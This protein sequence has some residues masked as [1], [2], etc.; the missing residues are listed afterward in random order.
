MTNTLWL[1]VYFHDT[2]YHGAEDWPPA[3]ARVFQ[4]LLSGAS[5][6]LKIAQDCEEALQW[7]EILS[8][9]IIIAPHHRRGQ[10]FTNYVPNND[11][12]RYGGD[13][14][15]VNKIRTAKIIHPILLDTDSPLNY[16]WDFD[17][18]DHH[19][20]QKICDMSLQL[21]QLGQGIDA[22]WAQGELITTSE[23]DQHLSSCPG[24]TYHPGSRDSTK[25][26]QW[27]DQPTK[28][29]LLSLKDRHRCMRKRLSYEGKK[30]AFTQPP[31]P[32]FRSVSYNAKETYFLFEIRQPSAHSHDPFAAW[33]ATQTTK[34]AV[35]IR[36]QVAKKLTQALPHKT[37]EIERFMIGRGATQTDKARRVRIIPLPSIGHPHADGMIRRVLVKVPPNCPL[38]TD[39]LNWV[40]SGLEYTTSK[41]P[42]AEYLSKTTDQNMLRHY[43]LDSPEKGYRTW[44]TVTPAALPQ[45]KSTL[46][47]RQDQD[48]V[49]DKDSGSYRMS[50]ESLTRQ[51]I[52]QSLHHRGLTTPVQSIRTQKEP[53]NHWSRPADQYAHGTRFHARSLHHIEITFSKPVH[54]IFAFGNGRFMGLGLMAPCKDDLHDVLAF[55]L[56]SQ[57][58]IA[59]RDHV[60]FLNAVRRALMSRAADNQKNITTLFS[61]HESSQA[62]RSGQHQHIF[63]TADDSNNDGYVD[64]LIVSAPWA[65]D[66][67]AKRPSSEEFIHFDRVVRHLSYLYAGKLG[68]VK[69]G[70]AFPLSE[71]DPMIR[72]SYR[73]ESR[74]LYHSTRYAKKNQDLKAVVIPDIMMECQRRGLP[75]PEVNVLQ[76]SAGPRGG[77]LVARISLHFKVFVRGPII[78]GRSSHRGGGVFVGS[79]TDKL[80]KRDPV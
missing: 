33:P 35:M 25:E 22:A 68:I 15:N 23:K 61:G 26:S 42:H 80:P 10:K 43:G 37:H 41:R 8:A 59:K 24:I 34:L 30:W 19:H 58:R 55:R 53:F 17:S 40:F 73:W 16:L 54:D 74:S 45:A 71:D 46:N 36:D 21:Y 7:L 4:A 67:K 63:L 64:R 44:R 79:T 3:P 65:C 48:P 39:D 76:V 32:L 52:K 49:G 57:T 31:K 14:K 28:G 20:A 70:P 38:R 13:P 78:L 75:R 77:N 66:R 12:D 9:P 72:P 6:G 1:R 29:S 50:H 60:A 2:R 62:A 56:D 5:R 69:L 51:A 18:C 11:L 27:F 47:V